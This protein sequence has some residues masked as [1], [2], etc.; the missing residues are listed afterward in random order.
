MVC[1]CEYL[2]WNR[3]FALPFWVAVTESMCLLTLFGRVCSKHLF[4]Q[5][6]DCLIYLFFLKLPLDGCLKKFVPLIWAVRITYI[7]LFAVPHGFS[8]GVCRI[9][10]DI[11][12]F[13]VFF[14]VCAVREKSKW[15]YYSCFKVYLLVLLIFIHCSSY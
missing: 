8:F 14:V 3:L 9:A 7:K 1:Y 2:C 6:L 12:F 10:T 15:F 13:L 5:A 4:L 11:S